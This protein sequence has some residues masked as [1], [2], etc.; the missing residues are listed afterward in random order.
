MPVTLNHLAIPARDAEATAGFLGAVLGV[1]VERDG[2]E[3]EFPCLRLGNAVQI[4]F[5]QAATVVPH[6][7]AFQVGTD[8][9]EHVVERLRAAGIAFG[10]DPEDPR[11]G[12]VTDPLGGSGRVYFVDRDGH[13]FEV[14]APR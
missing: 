11:N 1:P 9:F 14:C 6:H 2:A 12:D 10:N 3:D 7:V 4:L 13:L 5:Q 8:E